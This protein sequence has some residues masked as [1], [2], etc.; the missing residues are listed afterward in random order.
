MKLRYVLHRLIRR[1]T[2]S[3]GFRYST[4]L[5]RTNSKEQNNPTREGK[6]ITQNT[7]LVTHILNRPICSQ[8][9]AP[10]S[11]LSQHTK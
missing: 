9:E 4:S 8:A 7:P 11:N 6:D 3:A 1:N 10:A 5:Y 2:T